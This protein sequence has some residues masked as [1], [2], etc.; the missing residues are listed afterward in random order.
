MS[1]KALRFTAEI[2]KVQTTKDH[3]IRL[4]LDLPEGATA[5]QLMECYHRGA[6][7]EIAAL[8]IDKQRGINAISEGKERKSRWTPAETAGIDRLA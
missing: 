2:I 7:L 8:P 6:V 3:A 1:E 5:G 4:I